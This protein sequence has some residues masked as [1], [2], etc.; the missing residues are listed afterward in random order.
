LKYEVLNVQEEDLAEEALLSLQA[1]VVRLSH[2]EAPTDSGSFLAAYMRTITKECNDYFEEPEHKQ[3][4]PAGQI[5]HSLGAASLAAFSLI[6]KATFPRLITLYSDANSIAKQRALFDIF[7]QL[8]KAGTEVLGSGSAGYISAPDNPLEPFRD[9][10]F[11]MFSQSLMG[12]PAEEM[13]FRL[14]S[15]KCLLLL[16]N[17]QGVLQTNEIG[18]V[19]QY[20]DDIVLT[21]DSD[22]RTNLKDAAINALVDISRTNPTIIMEIT[23]PVFMARLP[24]SALST[25]STYKVTLEGLAR[26]SVERNI[27]DTLIRRLLNKL[28]VVLQNNGSA[29]YVQAILWTL[30]YTLSKRKLVE[31]PNLN[32]H[33]E[34]IVVLV[35]QLVLVARSGGPLSSLNAPAT[36]GILGR[37]LTLV[38][39][40]LGVLGKRRA[41]Q[42]VYTLFVDRPLSAVPFRNDV[43]EAER[44]TLILSTYLL[45]GISRDVSWSTSKKTIDIDPL[46]NYRP[47]CHIRTIRCFGYFNGWLIDH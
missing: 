11:E 12:T 42:Q 14:V 33:Y 9:R 7:A 47:R 29:N 20:L 43:P 5:L 16:C 13:S 24:D 41:G 21:E 39:R 35:S 8:L 31:D 32:G 4:K 3:A 10:L 1:I 26:L 40:A 37:L 28:E 30:H 38:V 6:L 2:S 18:M 23:L 46:M 34:K 19:V 15:L 45:A 25:E 44:L 27:S 17:I 22:G 36:I